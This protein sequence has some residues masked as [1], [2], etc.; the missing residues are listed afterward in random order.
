MV[1]FWTITLNT[2]VDIYLNIHQRLSDDVACANVLSR[3]PAGKGMNEARILA[4]LREA[5]GSAETISVTGL[6]GDGQRSEFVAEAA[7]MG[8]EDR[9]VAISGR[10]RENLTLVENGEELHIKTDGYS[11]QEDAFE[12]L[13]ALLE[14][15]REGDV[16]VLAGSLPPGVLK[17]HLERICGLVERRRGILIVDLPGHAYEWV[18]GYKVGLIKPNMV[19]LSQWH[20]DTLSGF[21]EGVS[22]ARR[23]SQE[24]PAVML[25]MGK[26]GVVLLTPDQDCLFG[27]GQV[28]K[29][30]VRSTVGCGDSLLAT[31]LYEFYARHASLD[32]ALLTGVAAAVAN[33]CSVKTA[34]ISFAEIEIMRPR[35]EVEVLAG[36]PAL[37]DD[38]SENL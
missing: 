37:K 38:S 20:G 22:A 2:A 27:Y 10:T 18:L 1:A 30:Q 13:L 25:S 29:E 33:C 9:F 32:Q 8:L 17:E 34:D 5:Y 6:V 19:E 35:C 7:R 28:D 24:G 11:L 3:T 4:A 15:V 23:L 12:Q 16:V 31:F 14:D 36:H 21:D 26:E